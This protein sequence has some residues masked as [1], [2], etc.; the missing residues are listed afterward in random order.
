VRLFFTHSNL[1]A[2][3][4][5]SARIAAVLAQPE[6]FCGRAVGCVISWGILI[7][8]FFG[9]IIRWLIGAHRN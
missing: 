5:V 9:K 8:S 4:T 3:P 6:L 1:K 7:W 2:E